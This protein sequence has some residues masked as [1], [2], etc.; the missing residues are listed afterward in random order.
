MVP[1]EQTYQKFT[2]ANF[3][4]PD[5]EVLALDSSS[6]GQPAPLGT[7]ALTTWQFNHLDGTRFV[8]SSSWAPAGF[9]FGGD[10]L[11]SSDTSFKWQ[12]ENGSSAEQ[13]TSL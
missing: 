3:L 6:L 11:Q 7:Q 12:I 5:G 8:D 4:S 2:Q 1:G 10:V 13:L 9:S